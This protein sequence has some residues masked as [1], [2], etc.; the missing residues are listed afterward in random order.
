MTHGTPEGR[1][2]GLPP[3]LSALLRAQDDGSRAEAWERFLE[4]YNRL[5]LHTA[6]GPSGAYDET[7]DRYVFVLQ[8]LKEDDFVRL[9][10]YTPEVRARFTTWL[11]VV[12]GR[13]CIDHHRKRYGYA[14]KSDESGESV[15]AQHRAE[16][17]RRLADLVTDEL[18]IERLGDSAGGP[19]M[20]LRRR[21][22]QEALAQAIGKLEPRDRLILR[23]RFHEGLTAME[24]AKSIGMPSPFHVYRRVNHVLVQLR[25]DLNGM[26]VAGP[27]P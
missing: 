10:R 25:A 11:V 2:N 15:P 7:M 9:R 8:R 21:E 23:L 24:T 16:L 27:R 1:S 26:G 19:E 6:R 4:K 13:L 5:L 18:D 14:A 3:E 12:A 20:E 22:L 17:R